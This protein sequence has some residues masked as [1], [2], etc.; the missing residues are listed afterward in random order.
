[1]KVEK[2][3][4]KVKGYFLFIFELFIDLKTYNGFI[5]LLLENCQGE[6]ELR[7]I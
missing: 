4:F 2:W 5:I 6:N 3:T 1:M 7:M